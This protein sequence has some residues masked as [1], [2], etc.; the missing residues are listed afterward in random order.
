MAGA[1]LMV[2]HVSMGVERKGHGPMLAGVICWPQAYLDQALIG[3]GD[4]LGVQM[5]KLVE[6]PRF[7]VAKSVAL[8]KSAL[9]I[10]ADG[11]IECWPG[12]C[13]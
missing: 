4:L 5:E 3:E 13:L 8:D 6:W 9:E 11:R 1:G 12:A 7:I 2:L 10:E